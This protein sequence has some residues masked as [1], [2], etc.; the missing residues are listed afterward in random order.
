MSKSVLRDKAKEFAKEVIFV[1]KDIK[2]EHKE[3]VLTNQLLSLLILAY[4]ARNF[5]TLSFIIPILQW[6]NLRVTSLPTDTQAVG[7]RPGFSL[8]SFSIWSL[9][10][11]HRV[12]LPT[13]Q[14][15]SSLGFSVD[16]SDTSR[17][18]LQDRGT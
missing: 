7:G 15:L 11:R 13:Q 6:V 16:S 17:M 9:S 1:C 4:L 18:L 8:E 12:A 5:W 2:T 10:L 3:T 14:A